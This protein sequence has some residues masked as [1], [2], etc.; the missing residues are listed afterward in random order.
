MR[1]HAICSLDFSS[2]DETAQILDAK[3]ADDTHL[4]VLLRLGSNEKDNSTVLISLPYSSISR[5]TS[6]AAKRQII[7]YTP[8]P[9]TALSA[10]L[11]PN[12]RPPAATS[13]QTIAITR[14]VVNKHTRHVFE[15]RFTPLKLVVNGRKNRRVIV[16]L[17]SDRKHYRVLDMDFKTRQGKGGKEGDG[18]A[19]AG[20]GSDAESGGDEESDGDE[21]GD[22]TMTE[23]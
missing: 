6:S 9:P 2:S 22:I 20:H 4:L 10:S 5:A 8:L 14:D 15:G 13:R 11:L 16:V 19:E 18:G 3:F 12:G 1:S 23:T 7:T 17:G 21:D